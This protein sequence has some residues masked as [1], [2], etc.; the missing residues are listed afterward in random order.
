MVMEMAPS[1]DT[2]SACLI[3][4]SEES[5]QLQPQDETRLNALRQHVLPHLNIDLLLQDLV[6]FH[7]QSDNA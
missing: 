3:A 1:P 5:L 4:Y 6:H 2:S 7:K